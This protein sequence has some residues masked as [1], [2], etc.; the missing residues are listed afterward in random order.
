MKSD[1]MATQHHETVTGL[2]VWALTAA[3]FLLAGATIV[4]TNLREKAKKRSKKGK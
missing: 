1:I 4:I 2:G 3:P